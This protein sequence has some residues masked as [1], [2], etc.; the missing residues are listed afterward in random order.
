MNFR[1]AFLILLLLVLISIIHLSI[2]TRNLNL[3]N[4]V[5]GLKRTLGG[6]KNEIRYLNSAAASRSNL[7][8]IEEIAL[9]KLRM[10]RPG[11]INYIN[12]ASREL[13]P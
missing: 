2:Y 13:S 9:G 11:D 8:R 10:I 6:M 5:E 12:A 3:K 1:R 7:K 4:E